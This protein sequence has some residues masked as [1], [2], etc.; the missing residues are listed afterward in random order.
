MIKSTPTK[1]NGHNFR[2]RLEARWAV[3]FDTIGIEWWYEMEGYQLPSGWYLPDFWLPQ[4]KMFAEVK[5]TKF[6]EL[7]FTKAKELVEGTGY[8][9]IL[10]DGVPDERTFLFVSNDFD[11]HFSDYLADKMC[12]CALSM[13]HDYPRNEARFYSCT[14]IAIGDKSDFDRQG[15]MFDDVPAAVMKAKSYRF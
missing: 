11:D 4:V 12:D 10:L 3:Y 13:Y 7:E 2:S 6:T 15:G 8:E 5:P 14:G 1:Y 9:C